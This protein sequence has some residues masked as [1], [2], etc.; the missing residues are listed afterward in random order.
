[1]ELAADDVYLTESQGAGFG[2]SHPRRAV[3][4]DVLRTVVDWGVALWVMLLVGLWW[5]HQIRRERDVWR[6]QRS[7]RQ[8]LDLETDADP[9]PAQGHDR[10]GIGSWAW[11]SKSAQFFTARQP[12]PSPA[13]EVY[14]SPRAVAEFIAGVEGLLR[15]DDEDSGS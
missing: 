1:V 12:K 2:Q 13:P 5:R 6:D 8:H 10:P 15:R 7:G 4:S 3:T 9:Y 14:V 11:S